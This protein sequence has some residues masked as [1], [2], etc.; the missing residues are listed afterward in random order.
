M[1]VADWDET[2][3]IGGYGGFNPDSRADEVVKLF[4]L[5]VN[6]DLGYDMEFLYESLISTIYGKSF[7]KILER[8]TDTATE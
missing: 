6:H 2:T 7:D 3:V 1:K 4:E 5:A 8:I